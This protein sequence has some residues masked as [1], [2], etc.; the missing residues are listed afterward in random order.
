MHWLTVAYSMTAAACLTLAAVHLFVLFKQPARRAHLAF[1]LTAI[2][3]AA[4]TP[5]EFAIG[6]AWVLNSKGGETILD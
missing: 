2:S 5:F 1:S 4:I 6:V 3:V